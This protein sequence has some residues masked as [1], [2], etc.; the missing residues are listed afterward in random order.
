MCGYSPRTVPIFKKF[1]GGTLK[2]VPKEITWPPTL[3]R[4]GVPGTRILY[5]AAMK[6]TGQVAQ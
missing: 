3:G 6:V 4:C 2:N 1:N 5:K